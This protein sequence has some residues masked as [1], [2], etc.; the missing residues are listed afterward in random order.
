MSLLARVLVVVALA[1]SASA[2][3]EVAPEPVTPRTGFQFAPLRTLAIQDR[4][5]LK[6][7]ETFAI[8]TV[9]TVTG[10]ARWNGMDSVEVLFG[11]LIAFDREWEDERI[12]KID[13]RAL[14][15][16]IGL[17]PD[18]K[19]FSSVELRDN[20]KLEAIVR[21]ATAKERRRERLETLEKKALELRNQI[22]L[23]DYV[24]SGQAFNVL[25]NPQGVDETWYSLTLLTQPP[26]V[27]PYTEAQTE[28]LQDQV[29]RLLKTFLSRDVAG[30]N[31]VV[32]EFVPFVQSDL[33]SKAYADPRRLAVEHH[34]NQLHPFRWS[35]VLYALSFVFFLAAAVTRQR[36][37]QL[38]A[39][40]TFVLGLLLHTYGFALRCYIAGRPP[41]TNMYESVIWVT[42]GCALLALVLRRFYPSDAIAASAAVFSAV[43]LVLADNLP[44]V[45]DPGIH[46]LEPVLR[47]NFWLTIHVLTITLSYAAFALALCIGNVVL[48]CYFGG[49][50]V[51]ERAQSLTLYMYRATQIGVVLLAA[52]TILG[53]VWADYSWGRFWGWDPKEVWALIALL[54]YLAVL[55]GRY[56]GW[57]KG[58]GF[59]TATVVSFLG[60]LMAWYGVNFVLGV[61]LHSYGFGTGGLGYVL[62]YLALQL[63]FVGAAYVR[64][65]KLVKEGAIST[66]IFPGRAS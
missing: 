36:P 33:G 64:Y 16:R 45:L 58:F 21:E 3:P 40:G 14:K 46:P 63:G 15:E 65:C 55:H 19:Y 60:V 44:N 12:F 27:P 4:G 30:W 31:A 28:R 26:E 24:A 62:G 51:A 47:S 8:E 34:F 20:E 42:W 43:G 54:L 25:P 38:S 39:Y 32:A 29:G 18:R 61:G 41:V 17:E 6:P 56:T 13:F 10:K 59:V 50:S 66:A 7:L 2:L 53:G 22:A 52:G 9:R 5:R 37:M 23:I 48:G 1:T 57:L 49:K 11:W 35:W